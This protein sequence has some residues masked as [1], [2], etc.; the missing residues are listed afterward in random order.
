MYTIIGFN[1]PIW[2]SVLA[3]LFPSARCYLGSQLKLP[4]C[5]MAP[6]TWHEAPHVYYICCPTLLPGPL[7]LQSVIPEGNTEHW[8]PK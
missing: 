6:N 2:L 3:R 5:L 4:G 8:A 1:Q 7:A